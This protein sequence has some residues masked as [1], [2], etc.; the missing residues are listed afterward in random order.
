[1]LDFV[2]YKDNNKTSIHCRP[3]LRYI[4]SG[5]SI[6]IKFFIQIRSLTTWG[7]NAAFQFYVS[8]KTIFHRGHKR[9]EDQILYKKNLDFSYLISYA[10]LGHHNLGIDP[11]PDSAKRSQKH[12]VSYQNG[13]PWLRFSL[14]RS[15]WLAP[16]CKGQ[17]KLELFV[18]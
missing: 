3:E 17:R 9:H 12:N 18:Q 14:F 16:P 1:M 15:F 13:L 10:I 5:S 8:F 6:S 11:D 2:L 4:G 7:Q